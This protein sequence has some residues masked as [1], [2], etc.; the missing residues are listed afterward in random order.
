M[1]FLKKLTNTDVKRRN[2]V[3]QIGDGCDFFHVKFTPEG[4][5]PPPI[6]INID[7][8]PYELRMDKNGYQ[9]ELL[10]FRNYLQEKGAKEGDILVLKKDPC[11]WGV[12][13]AGTDNDVWNEKKEEH[14]FPF[15]DL[16]RKQMRKS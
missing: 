7:R 6:K 8:K 15:M 2:F 10:E 12:T 3:L 14:I 4:N 1:F 16:Y 13:R 5:Y 9:F 11:R